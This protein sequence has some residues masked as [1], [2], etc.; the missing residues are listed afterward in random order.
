MMARSV[1]VVKLQL[2]QQRLRRFERGNLTVAAFCQAE[3]VSLPS[4]Y[5]WRRKIV[6]SHDPVG[7]RR[8]EAPRF[9]EVPVAGKPAFLPVE[10]VQ[11]AQAATIEIHLPNGARLAVPAGDQA[12]LEAAIA[13]VGRLPR[14]VPKAANVEVKAC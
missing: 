13:A 5:H 1:D 6:A 12:T 11:A 2:W 4:F 3:R 8:Q 9:P 7:A 10:I 14:M